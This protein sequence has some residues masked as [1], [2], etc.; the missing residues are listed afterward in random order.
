MHL[1][2]LGFEEDSTIPMHEIA[3]LQLIEA[4][5]LFLQGK[6]LCALTLAGAAEGVLAGL[7][8]VNGLDSVVEESTR[9]ITE[10]IRAIG[11]QTIRPKK[12]TEYYN[13]WNK[14]RNSVKHYNKNES[15]GVTLNQFDEAYWMIER[16][17][18]NAELASISV[19]N[20]DEYRNWII[21]NINM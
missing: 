18:R 16:A 14:A 10:L 12:A 11:L 19:T 20:R 9:K 13:Q 8:A 1:P 7:L 5:N 6:F 2:T 17:L 15:E 4:I 3:R 21:V